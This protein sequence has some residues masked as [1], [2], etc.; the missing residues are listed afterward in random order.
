MV[1]HVRPPDGA[2]DSEPASHDSRQGAIDGIGSVLLHLRTGDD[3][4]L[5]FTATHLDYGR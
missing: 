1:T 3:D 5:Y 2:R 4:V